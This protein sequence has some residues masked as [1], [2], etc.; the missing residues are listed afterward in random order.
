MKREDIIIEKIWMKWNKDKRIYEMNLNDMY[1]ILYERIKSEIKNELWEWEGYNDW[2][3]RVIVFGV[4][5]WRMR[6]I[7]FGVMK[8]RVRIILFEELK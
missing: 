6:I 5:N 1:C 2:R 7:V 8:W 3:V 4:M